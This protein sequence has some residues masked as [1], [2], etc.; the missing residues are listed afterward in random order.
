MHLARVGGAL[1]PADPVLDPPL[2]GDCGA[3]RLSSGYCRFVGHLLLA[4]A[5]PFPSVWLRDQWVGLDLTLI[6]GTE[7]THPVVGRRN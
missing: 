2:V 5:A 6:L 1:A 7:P 3:S 4:P